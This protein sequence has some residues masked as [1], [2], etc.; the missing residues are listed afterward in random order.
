MLP[1]GYKFEL[2]ELVEKQMELQRKKTVGLAN[3]QRPEIQNEVK[4]QKIYQKYLQKRERER[5]KLEANWAAM[6]Q[7]AAVNDMAPSGIRDLNALKVSQDK[8]EAIGGK[9]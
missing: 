5:L 8:H 3:Y 6:Q 4:M 9:V 1:K 7:S 2:L